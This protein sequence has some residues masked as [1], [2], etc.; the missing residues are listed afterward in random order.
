MLK[1]SELSSGSEIAFIGMIKNV[2]YDQE[3]L[4]IKHMLSNMLPETISNK[5]QSG[6]KEIAQEVEGTVVFIDLVGFT[7]YMY[8]IL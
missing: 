7:T 1:V 8:V 3:L 6:E 5:I 2:T 4:R